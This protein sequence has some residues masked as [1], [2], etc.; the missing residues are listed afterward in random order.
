MTISSN[1]TSFV[2]KK[3]ERAAAQAIATSLPLQATLARMLDEKLLP[4]QRVMRRLNETAIAP[5]DVAKFGS[6]V[7]AMK[8]VIN[9]GVFGDV[10]RFLSWTFDDI[11]IFLYVAGVC[12]PIVLDLEKSGEKGIA[13][14]LRT[15]IELLKNH[16]ALDI[17]P[18]NLTQ[19]GDWEVER[20]A[21]LNE[22]ISGILAG[23]PESAE[24]DEFVAVLTSY[25]DHVTFER[26]VRAA[27][28]L[29]GQ[30][31]SAYGLVPKRFFT[32]IG[33]VWA[34]EG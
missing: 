6:I 5:A 1:T 18:K 13:K 32:T 9:V 14:S 20:R 31:A 23:Q 16:P 12:A 11:A 27:Q 33:A 25:L 29:H 28:H 7:D 34:Q 26:A 10:D 24:R 19:R 4:K 15:A 22:L 21:E 2:G 17:D 3:A 30:V 8:S